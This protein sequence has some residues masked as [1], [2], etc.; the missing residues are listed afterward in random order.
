M[1]ILRCCG[2]VPLP[3]PTP[4]APSPSPEGKSS[5]K[6]E[7]NERLIFYSNPVPRGGKIREPKW[8][9]LVGEIH[10]SSV[11]GGA[12]FLKRAIHESPP[13]RGRQGAL[14][15]G[16]M[17]FCRGNVTFACGKPT[18]IL[19]GSCCEKALRSFSCTFA[20][21]LRSTRKSSTAQPPLCGACSLRMTR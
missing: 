8:G 21:S 6:E 13:T 15:C 17:A 4:P 9:I 14:G 2:S 16:L 12:C 10:E 19:Y 7:N 3:P 11:Q 20:C 5:I 1:R 18:V